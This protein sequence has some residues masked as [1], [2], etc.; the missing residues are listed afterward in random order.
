[1]DTGQLPDTSLHEVQCRVKRFIIQW[2]A[3]LLCFL[4][5]IFFAQ[6]QFYMNEILKDLPS[7]STFFHNQDWPV[8][9]TLNI[10]GKKTRV[11]AEHLQEKKKTNHTW[12]FFG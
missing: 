4:Y 9:P 1:M 5:F 6:L 8:S 2:Y 11:A 7:C 12:G 10:T 3:Y